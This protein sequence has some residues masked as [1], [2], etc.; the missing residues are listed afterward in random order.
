M[1]GFISQRRLFL[2]KKN[3]K[4]FLDEGF[5]PNKEQKKTQQS[6]HINMASLSQEHTLN[7]ATTSQFD[8]EDTTVAT[9]K[10]MEDF[11]NRNQRFK[12]RFIEYFSKKDRARYPPYNVSHA[13]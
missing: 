9:N 2:T 1:K 13:R 7:M 3:Q 11:S 8:H 10:T 5:F 12:N 6:K 4:N